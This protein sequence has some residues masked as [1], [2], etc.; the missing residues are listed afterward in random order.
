MDWMTA[1]LFLLAASTPAPKPVMKPLAAIGA[2]DVVTNSEVRAAFKRPFAKGSGDAS[3]CEYVALDQQVVAIKMQHSIQKLDVA[4]EMLT[5]RKAFPEGRMRD[6]KGFSSP[7]F[8]MDLPGIGTQL[9][10]IRGGHDFLLVSVMGIGEP[11]KVAAGAM[12]V[13]KIALERLPSVE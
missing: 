7:A 9:F 5:L 11:K 1:L 8:F 10:V 2:C 4:A 12:H 3:S 6:A 13:A